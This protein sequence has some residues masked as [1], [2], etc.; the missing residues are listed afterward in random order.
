MKIKSQLMKGLGL[1]KMITY[2][3]EVGDWI[4]FMMNNR[5]T[6][7]E[8]VY[9]IPRK[10]WQEIDILTTDCGEVSAE[11]VLEVRSGRTKN[12]N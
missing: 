6:I 3:Y 8:I 7:G 2:K 9:I 5:L 10:A 11:M 4:R 1:I 12:E